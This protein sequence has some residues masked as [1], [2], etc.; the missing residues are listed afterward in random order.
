MP[1]DK[2]VT[3]TVLTTYVDGKPHYQGDDFAAAAGEW[4]AVTS[5]MGR[6]VPGGISI[7]SFNAEGIMLRDGWLIHVH[8][9]GT[10]YVSPSGLAVV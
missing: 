6:A 9:D 4:D 2:K 3:R 1:L 5:T 7:Q 10:T 8:N